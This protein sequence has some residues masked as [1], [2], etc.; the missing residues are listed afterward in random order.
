MK[1]DTMNTVLHFTLA[2]LVTA[3]VIFAIMAMWR[4]RDY[5]ILNL[6]VNVANYNLMR[7]QSLANDTAAYN[8]TKQD[9]NLTKVLQ[10]LQARPA[11]PA[12]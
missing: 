1:D 7:F 5:R 3:G 2:V 6:Q 9:P 8:Q 10:S 12:K 4:A 11:A